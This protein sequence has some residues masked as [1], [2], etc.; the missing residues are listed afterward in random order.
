MNIKLI[1]I[2]VTCLLLST[3]ITLVATSSI[4][5][6]CYNANAE[7]KKTKEGNATFTLVTMIIGVLM[8]LSAIGSMYIGI[9]YV[10]ST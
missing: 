4:A 6:E 2:G 10:P 8:I 7:F 9:K 3:A 5:T 1:V